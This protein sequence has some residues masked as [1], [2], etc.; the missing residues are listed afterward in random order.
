MR[1]LL[2]THAFLWFI[3]DDPRLSRIARGV[4]ED[5]ASE[6]FLSLASVWEMAVK[7]RLAKLS[8]EKPLKEFIE[9]ECAK[10]EIQILPIT[11]DH[12]E[13]TVGLP[14][15]HRDPFDRLLIAQCQ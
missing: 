5:Q 8:I 3:A 14:M 6:V 7:I 12:I 1:L 2:D 13:K 11:I 9:A 4:I 10:N 15:L